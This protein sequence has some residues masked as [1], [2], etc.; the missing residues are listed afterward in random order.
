MRLLLY[1]LFYRTVEEL[2]IAIILTK[3]ELESYGKPL[4]EEVAKSLSD[5]L[6]FRLGLFTGPTR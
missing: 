5:S 3:A 1:I 6:S 2:P 4:A